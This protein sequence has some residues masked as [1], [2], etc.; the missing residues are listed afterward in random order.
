[1]ST[2]VVTA[3]R[4]FALR[5]LGCLAAWSGVVRPAALGCHRNIDY[6]DESEERKAEVIQ[7]S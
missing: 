2:R 1:M 6:T 4:G 5:G 3:I 7:L